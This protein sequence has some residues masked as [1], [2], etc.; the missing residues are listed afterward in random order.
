MVSIIIDLSNVAL[1]KYKLRIELLN[2]WQASIIKGNAG[3]IGAIL[4]SAEVSSFGFV[5]LI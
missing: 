4:G 3:E 1:L 2:S 5:K